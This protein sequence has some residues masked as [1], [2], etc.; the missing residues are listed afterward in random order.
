MPRQ[1]R[2]EEEDRPKRLKVP[3]LTVGDINHDIAVQAAHYGAWADEVAR[4]ETLVD[5][6]EERLEELCSGL[7]EEL[8][9]TLMLTRGRSLVTERAV[10]DMLLQ[11]PAVLKQRKSLRSLRAK[12]KAAKAILNALDVKTKMLMSLAGLRRS[13]MQALNGS[14]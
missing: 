12:Y 8:R 14:E 1:S 10:T 4:L 11:N 6:R 13:E 9:D 2:D 5:N 3:K 7:R